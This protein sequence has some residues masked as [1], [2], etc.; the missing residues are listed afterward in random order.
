M[1]PSPCSDQYAVTSP[2][3]QQRQNISPGSGSGSGSVPRGHRRRPAGAD[4][5]EESEEE[6]EA[7]KRLHSGFLAHLGHVA[8][9]FCCS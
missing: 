7:G 8:A 5:G 3:F 2:V 1:L 6:E 4:S 9:Q